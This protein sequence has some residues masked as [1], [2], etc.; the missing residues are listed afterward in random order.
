MEKIINPNI[1]QKISI[2]R[3]LD[4]NSLKYYEII[5]SKLNSYGMD[6]IMIVG[7]LIT[8]IFQILKFYKTKSSKGFSKY[9]CLFLFLGNILRICFWYGTRFSNI[10]LY[11]SI[12]IV[13]FQIILIHLCCKFQEEPFN[14]SKSEIPEIK[15]N[16]DIQSKIESKN[17][18]NLIKNFIAAYFSKTFKP[19]YFKWL[20]CSK[21]FK[22]K[23]FWNWQKEK[24]YYRFMLL[25][26]LL[27]FCLGSIFK[28]EKFFFDIIGSISAF[29]E[30]FICFPQIVSNFRTKET[31]NISFMMILS[32]LL[33]DSFKLFYNI[34]FNSPIQLIIGISIQ[35]IFDMIVII[36][37]IL[38]RNKKFNEKN[39][40]NSNKKQIE[41]I[42][43]LMKSIDEL[44]VAK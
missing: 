28:K 3:L 11:Q 9:I 44:N 22:P 14:D 19:K 37:L 4:E 27:L 35:V 15:N 24:E 10:L 43:Q 6:I 7:P 29:F 17:N 33:G 12:G 25:I 32:W 16:N 23:L 2:N 21:I 30:A 13:I 20:F 18:I 1:F 31:K 5:F 34:K 41:E 8:Y 39:I 42:N 36:Q 26:I 40:I 38:Y